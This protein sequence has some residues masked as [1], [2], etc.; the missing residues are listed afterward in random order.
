MNFDLSQKFQRI[1]LAGMVQEAELAYEF[2]YV[3]DPKYFSGEQMVI[4]CGALFD[5]MD[6]YGAH[7]R[8]SVL[9]DKI[10][11]ECHKWADENI[12]ADTLKLLKKLYATRIQDI[13]YIGNRVRSFAEEAE[14]RSIMTDGPDLVDQGNFE[15]LFD[16][17][18]TAREKGFSDGIYN[19]K[20]Q[21]RARLDR[22][23]ETAI[24]GT[25]PTG[26]KHLD[27]KVKIYPPALCMVIG[28]SS[29]GKTWFG[30]HLARVALKKG[31]NVAFF[32]GEMTQDEISTRFDA[33]VLGINTAHFMMPEVHKEIIKELEKRYEKLKGNLII[34]E[35]QAQAY[36]I[37]RLEIDIRRL[38]M[39]PET[40]PKVVIIDYLEL[41]T[42][43]DSA[44]RKFQGW[45][46]LIKIVT[47][48]KGIAN[49][50]KLVV[51]LIG[52]IIG[53]ADESGLMTRKNKAQS[54]GTIYGPDYMFT[55]NRSQKDIE[56]G[57]ILIYNDKARHMKDQLIV[58]VA[59][60]FDNSRFC[61]KSLGAIYRSQLKSKKKD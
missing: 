16:R 44:T 41:L 36:P 53:E 21:M 12:A 49:K 24:G 61:V 5:Y 22:L 2:R 32:T 19:T 6:N 8:P 45:E 1:L 14:W 17:A 23:A 20:E 28:E 40:S 54:R 7:P 26:I 13:G 4:I 57:R 43:K 39:N 58:G 35:F 27:R 25:I 46:E 47:S 31:H 50:Y 18:A 33:S 30:A 52:T 9:A 37:S 60:S 51:W 29:A 59:P 42:Y 3:V 10:S 56:L 11:K 55:L 34:K 48:A 38:M 15:E